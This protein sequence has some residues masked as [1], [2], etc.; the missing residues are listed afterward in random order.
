MGRQCRQASAGSSA[1]APGNSAGWAT[2]HA[3]NRKFGPSCTPNRVR[4]LAVRWPV[5]RQG[6][7]QETST[8]HHMT[9]ANQRA[10]LLPHICAPVPCC[11]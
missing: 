8:A 11:T 5:D 7:P 9:A 4:H 1:L 10:K 3:I 2:M 6:Q